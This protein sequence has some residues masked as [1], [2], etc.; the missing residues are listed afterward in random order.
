MSAF[1]EGGGAYTYRWFKDWTPVPNGGRFAGS[2]SDH[3]IISGVTV[4]D[5]G[6]YL[7][8]VTDSCGETF[9]T[10]PVNLPVAI[11]LRL[12]MQPVE[13]GIEFRLV[14]FRGTWRR[15]FE[16][17][18]DLSH[19]ETI[20]TVSNYLTNLFLLPGSPQNQPWRFYRAAV[21]N[22]MGWE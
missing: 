20:A 15:R 6:T 12:L 16:G 21:L 3:L 8:A 14:P 5:A 11:D 22:P 4:A 18:T 2:L 19:W 17:S 13:N 1:V 10:N 7:A 9:F